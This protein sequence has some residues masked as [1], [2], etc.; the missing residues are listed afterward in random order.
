MRLTWFLIL[1]FLLCSTTFQVVV[2]A[3]IIRIEASPPQVALRGKDSS[4]QLLITGFDATGHAQ[5]LTHQARYRHSAT[6]ADISSTGIV[7]GILD[8]A[9]IITARYA[10]RSIKIPVSITDA[11][12]RQPL[13]FTNDIIPILSRYRCNTSGC[14]GKA[15]GQNG[16]KLSVFGFD[17]LADYR[18][19]TMEARGRRIFPAAAEMSLLMQKMSGDLPHGGGILIPSS[20]AEYRKITEWIAAGVPWENKDDVTVVSISLTPDQRILRMGETQ[21]LRV[22]AKMSNA[23]NVDVT[24]LAQFQS[25]ATSQASVNADGQVTVGQKPG[26]VAVMATYMGSVDVFR[27]FIPEGDPIQEYPV[28]TSS[29]EIDES[30]YRQLQKMNIIASG[31][32]TDEQFLRRVFIDLTGTVPT[33]DQTA[34]FLSDQDPDKRDKLVDERLESPEFN[35]YWALKWSDLLRVDRQTLG[36]ENAYQYY[37]WIKESFRQHKPM[38]KF[39]REL[40]T[41]SGPLVDAPAGFFYKAV[42]SPNRMASTMSQVLLGIRIECAECHHHPFDRWGQT[43]FYGMRAF[44]AQVRYKKS[45]RGEMLIAQGNP[46]TKHPRTGETIQ[47]FALGT[48][49]P[50]VNPLNDRR[51]E[52]ANWLTAPENPWFASNIANRTWAHLMGRGIIEPVDD[53]RLTNP[54]TNPELLEGLTKAFVGAEFDFRKLLKLIIQTDAYQRSSA[55]NETNERDEQN[56]SRFLFKQLEAEVMLDAICQTTGVAEK[57]QGVPVGSR[58]ID[59]WDSSVPHYFLETFGRPVRATACECERISEPTVSQVLHILNSPGIEN[60]LSHEAGTIRQIASD[61]EDNEIAIQRL[62]LT[63]FNRYGDKQE[64]ATAVQYVTHG[65]NRRQSLEDI[66]WSMLNSLEFLFNH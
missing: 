60:K 13:S 62:Y 14:H 6:G 17:P 32:C 38:D 1:P 58:A 20:R 46:V 30:I 39:A 26:V 33:A 43:D 65:S 48:Q 34:L 52:L 49:M 45:S 3:E 57:F 11:Q 59:L 55:V 18:A 35:S 53:V 37:S 31:T 66:A 4:I 54:P 28:V 2:S 7:R 9:S 19:I 25:N 40:I 12:I 16:F 15:E 36:H 23:E 47:A 50:T 24:E 44:F 5:D 22:M 61:Y 42:K 10:G 21:Q 27:I 41:T 63:F 51:D 8:G 56:Y 29:N 64:I